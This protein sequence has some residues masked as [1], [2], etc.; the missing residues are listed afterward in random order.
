[1][2]KIKLRVEEVNVSS[3][4][5]MI[6]SCEELPNKKL[7][8]VIGEFEA[9]YVHN[10]LKG[11]IMPRPMTYELLL[12]LIQIADIKIREVFVY[13]FSE[14]IF[15]SRIIGSYSEADFEIDARTSDAVAVS[16]KLDVPLFIDKHLFVSLSADKS[17]FEVEDENDTD[18]VASINPFDMMPLDELQDMLNDAVEREEYEFAEFLKNIMERRKQ[19]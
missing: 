5:M 13:K 15:Y 10:L 8:I 12:S 9:V 11:V 1:M 4:F 18:T 2:D 3:C 17:L 6:L 19:D 16:L 14:G 7:P